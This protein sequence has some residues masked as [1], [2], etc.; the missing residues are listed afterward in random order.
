MITAQRYHDFSCGHRVFGHE[1][2]CSH[3]HGHN[4]RIYFEI[5]PMRSLD[6]IGRVLDFSVMKEKFCVWLEENWDHKFLVYKDD[7]FA[8]ELKKIDPDG[9]VIVNFNPTAEN[10]AIYLSDISINLLK[11]T[12][13][14]IQSIKIEETRK[15][16]VTWNAD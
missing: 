2:K 3:L 1:S 14:K 6:N 12:D 5:I 4:Y 7:P 13:C 11:G 15:C 8:N 16:A 10:M 9:V